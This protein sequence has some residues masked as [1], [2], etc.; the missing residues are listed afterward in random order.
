MSLAAHHDTLVWILPPLLPR[1]DAW[2]PPTI[3]QMGK[4]KTVSAFHG[5]VQ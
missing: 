4:E 1:G 3:L 5:D 2:F